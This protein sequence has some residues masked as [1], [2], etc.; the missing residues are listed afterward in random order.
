MAM[1]NMHTKYINI[2]IIVNSHIQFQNIL[3]VI[4][5]GNSERKVGDK[6]AVLIFMLVTQGH[7]T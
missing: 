1:Y 6:E 5:Q 2:P 3:I 4:H 7:S